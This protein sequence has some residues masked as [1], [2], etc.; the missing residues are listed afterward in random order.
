[1]FCSI[2]FDGLFSLA[3]TTAL[4]RAPNDNVPILWESRHSQTQS[5][6]RFQFDKWWLQ[7]NKFRELLVK[8]CNSKM[9]GVSGLERWQNEVILFRRKARG[10]NANVEAELRRRN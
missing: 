9:A 7:H 4:P 6:S 8:V 1:V 2:K 10:W 3:T 5:R